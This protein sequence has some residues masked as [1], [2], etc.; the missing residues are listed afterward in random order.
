MKIT[1]DFHTHTIY[2]SGFLIKGMHAK[3]TIEENVK[4]AYKKGLQTIVISEHGPSHYLYG[5]RK[6]NLKLIREEVNRLNEIYSP[7]GLKVLMGLESNLVGLN[8]QIDVDENIIE[9]IDILLMGFHYGSTPKSVREGM[10]LYV[11]S[12]IAKLS[13][14]KLDEITEVITESYISAIKNFPINIITHPGAKVNLDIL[15]LAQEA[16]KR[17]VALEINSR[18]GNLN[19]EDLKLLKNTN[20]KFY[21]NSDAHSSK[22]VGNFECGLE[23]FLSSGLDKNRVVN[24]I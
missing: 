17:D 19:L 14:Y 18:H 23:I 2:S 3:S 5:V 6:K 13:G 21:I 24:A 7:K 22:E 8:G 1:G 11:K 15:K 12:Q 10:N 20:V 16:E 4:A 9:M